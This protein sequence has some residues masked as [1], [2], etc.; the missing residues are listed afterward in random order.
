MII[1][2]TSN[3]VY[4]Y[5]NIVVVYINIFTYIFLFVFFFSMLF[6]FEQ[7]NFKVLSDLKIFYKLDFLSISSI[8]ILLSMSG[9]PPFIGFFSKFLVF[10]YFFYQQKYIFIIFF[11][12]LS[13]F[14]IYFYIQNLRFL[15]SKT[16]IGYLPKKGFFRFLNTRLVNLIVLLSFINFFSIFYLEDMLYFFIQITLLKNFF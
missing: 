15:V 9:I 10:I 12:I 2:N 11:S 1:F 13:F 7:K 14:T 3:I 6:L 8:T 16:S 5:Y 4:N